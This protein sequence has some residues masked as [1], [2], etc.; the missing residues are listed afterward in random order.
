LAKVLFWE[1]AEGYEI[2]LMRA[3]LPLA[4]RATLL[5]D[6][7]AA[8]GYYALAAAVA[9]PKLRVVAF[10]PT[11]G[12]YD[13]LVRNVE[14]NDASNVTSE[15]L[16]LGD[17]EGRLEFYVTRNPKF[18]GMA[19]LAGTSGFD[20]DGATRG[21]ITPDRVDVTVVTLDGYVAERLG[22]Q[23]VDLLKL[24]T[25]A[26]EDRVLA[27]A[28][29]VLSEHRPVVLCEVLPGRIEEAL[30]AAFAAHNYTFARALPGG[31]QLAEH[32]RHGPDVPNDHVMI[33][34]ERLDE[35]RSIVQWRD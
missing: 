18:P 2:D 11:P 21:G 30:E 6:V 12:T 22:G 9:N 5:L 26:T 27:G 23:R 8:L 24:D 20:S 14:L 15:Q 35:V 3:F 25:E 32:L 4:S 10:E 13:Y 31:L 28:G 1:G 33:P 17:A 34:R 19:Q 16:A 29:R 7:G